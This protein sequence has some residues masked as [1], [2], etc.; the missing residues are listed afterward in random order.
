MSFLAVAASFSGIFMGL[1][2]IP[3]ILRILRR[4]SAADISVTTHLIIFLGAL[5][6][7]LYGLELRNDPIVYSNIIGL[8]LNALIV[9]LF[10]YYKN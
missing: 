7:L 1:S 2:G 5:I 10:F 4:K 9:V 8:V 3:Q 6:W